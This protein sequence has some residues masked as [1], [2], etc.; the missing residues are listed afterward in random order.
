M[1]FES[2]GDAGLANAAYQAAY[3]D[4]PTDQSAFDM[5]RSAE[6]SGDMDQALNAYAALLD[7]ADVRSRSEKGWNP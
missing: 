6:E 5:G 1:V 4:H 2:R 7:A 3:E